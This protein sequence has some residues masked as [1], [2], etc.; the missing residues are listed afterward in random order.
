MR[1]LLVC[2]VGATDRHWEF[3]R[4]DGIRFAAAPDEAAEI[5]D[6]MNVIPR[7]RA[8]NGLMNQRDVSSSRVA[9]QENQDRSHVIN[10]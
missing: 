3:A 6:G 1:W 8:G 9:R 7:R 10:I 2:R 5:V 4:R